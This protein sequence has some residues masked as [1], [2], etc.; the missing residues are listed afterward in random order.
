MITGCLLFA[1]V[2]LRLL[3]FAFVCFPAKKRKKQRKETLPLVDKKN[4]SCR[5]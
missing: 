1:F 2:C 4:L 3:S 5:R